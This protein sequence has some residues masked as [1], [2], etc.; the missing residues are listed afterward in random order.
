MPASTGDIAGQGHALHGLARGHARSGQFAEADPCFQDALRHFAAAGDH[1]SQAH[2]HASLAWVAER[3][4]RPADALG[5]SLAALD[6]HHAAGR[7]G[8]GAVM[9]LNDVGYCHALLGNYAEAVAYCER[10]LAA[11]QELG[12]R[13]WEAATWGLGYI[14]HQLGDHGRAV[15]SYE[16]AIGI[17]RELEA[18]G[19]LQLGRAEPAD[20]LRVQV[21]HQRPAVDRCVTA[22]P[23]TALERRQRA[24]AG[25][26]CLR[27]HGRLLP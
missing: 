7:P 25:R 1:V 22:G 9:A 26:R 21:L 24:R 18:A 13:N 19:E 5:H 27:G 8:P 14:H 3:Q 4:Q 23:G 12:E 16:R 15:S 10:A 6:L 2:V 20:E 17:Y 11:S